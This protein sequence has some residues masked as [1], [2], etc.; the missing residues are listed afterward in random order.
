MRTSYELTSEMLV[1]CKITK[2][3]LEEKCYVS[4]KGSFHFWRVHLGDGKERLSR[5]PWIRHEPEEAEINLNFIRA[6][7]LV[8]RGPMLCWKFE[9]RAFTARLIIYYVNQPI[10]HAAV[11]AL[12]QRLRYATLCPDYFSLKIYPDPFPFCQNIPSFYSWID[13]VKLFSSSRENPD[14]TFMIYSSPIVILSTDAHEERF[15]EEQKP[16][17]ARDRSIRHLLPGSSDCDLHRQGVQILLSVLLPHLER[18][19]LEHFPV[20]R[21]WIKDARNDAR[22]NRSIACLRKLLALVSIFVISSTIRIDRNNRR[23]EN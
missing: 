6:T 22:R 11:I 17:Q 19:L 14:Q 16:G 5:V 18:G 10:G 4:R 13:P 2:V 12:F 20:K 1:N 9:T 21:V 3:N 7:P 8:P 23:K 15:G